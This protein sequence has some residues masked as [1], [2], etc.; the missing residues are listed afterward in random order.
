VTEA[1][2]LLLGSELH[3]GVFTTGEEDLSVATRRLTDLMIDA[4][5]LA[6]GYEVL[7]VGCGTGGPA[8]RLAAEHGVK[9]VGITTSAIGVETARRLAAQEGVEERVEFACRDGMDNGFPDNA[10]DRV[11]V[12]ESSHLMRRRDRLIAECA[13]VLRPGGVLALCDIVLQRPMPFEEV[14]RLREPLSL[15]RTVFGDARMEPLGVYAELARQND[16][17]VDEERDL[18]VETRPTLARWRENAERHREAVVA[19]LS[20]QGWQD[21]VDA[22]TVLENFWSDGTL[23]Y[24]LLAASKPER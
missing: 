4:A 17:V 8:F 13:R 10:F 15:L 3:Y 19:K 11:W 24:G 23:G 9:V 1:W 22:C 12:L 20:E 2:G 16:L 18:T 21:F 7:D 5:R 6:P 14:R